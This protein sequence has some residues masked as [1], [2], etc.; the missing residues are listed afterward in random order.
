[1]SACDS[2]FAANEPSTTMRE[3]PAAASKVAVRRVFLWRAIEIEQ[4]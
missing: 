4:K 2:G 1:M 3:G